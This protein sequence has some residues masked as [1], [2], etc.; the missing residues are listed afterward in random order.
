MRRL[1][2]TL[3]RGGAVAIDTE[4][5]SLHHY[6]G[7]LCLVQ[8]PTPRGGNT[9][10]IRSRCPTSRRW[11]PL[12]PIPDT[13]KVLHAADNDLGLPQAALRLHGDLA[14]RHRG[15]RAVPRRARARP[16]RAACTQYLGVTPVKSRQKDDWSRR[17]L[18]A[19][20]EAYALNDVLHLIPLR[21]RLLESPPRDR[22]GPVGGG[23]MRGA[24]RAGGAREPADPDAYMKIK[25]AG[26]WTRAGSGCCASSIAARETLALRLDRPPFMIVGNES[27]VVLAARRPL[28]AE[29]ILAVPG[30]HAAGR[31]PRGPRHPRGDRA[32]A[33]GAGRGP[34]RATVRSPGRT[35]P[36]PS[37]GAGRRCASGAPRPRRRSASIRGCSFPSASSTG[38][39]R[40]PAAPTLPRFDRSR[41]CATGASRWAGRNCSR[42]SAPPDP[43]ADPPGWWYPWGQEHRPPRL[44]AVRWDMEDAL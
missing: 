10:W 5:D 7:K 25:G 17:P 43:L 34:A 29:G 40:P 35:C 8:M 20:Q 23:G 39:P 38:S 14:L 42:F 18:T 4:A 3:A 28:D 19:E 26:S 41:A 33:R 16:G 22:A 15:G 30:L 37:G 36:G 13:L 21:E 24:G 11:A 27:L 1:A 6:P 2:A 9:W 32:R 12:L 31:A 44:M